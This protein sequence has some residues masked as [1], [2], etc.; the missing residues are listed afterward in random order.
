[1]L[2][3]ARWTPFA[4][5]MMRPFLAALLIMPTSHAHSEDRIATARPRAEA[6]LLAAFQKAG[7]TYPPTSLLLRAFKR[8]AELELW[9]T[10]EDGK[11]LKVTTYPV[12]AASGE[13]G[14]KRKEG[15]QQVP[16]G[17]YKIN[18]Y[19]PKSLFHL[20]LGLNYPNAADRILS[21]P[22][23]PGSDIFIH[24]KDVTIGCLPMG[25]QAIEQIY[26]AALDTKTK[27]VSVHIFPARMS[28]DSW[29]PWRDAEVAKHPALAGFWAQLQAGYDAFERNRSL[30]EI[31]I[32]PDGSYRVSN[33]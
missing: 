10:G 14:P 2:P 26:I 15:D 28:G 13:P 22:K 1:M 25:D 6:V 8:E 30:L 5:K 24:G 20:S 18:R 9:A 17:F 31:G 12:L 33:R 7:A 29:L 3:V 32:A 27:P 21:D 23:Q 11:F 19:N 16:E 4:A